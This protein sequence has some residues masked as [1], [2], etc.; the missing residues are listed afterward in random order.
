MR[1]YRTEFPDFDPATMPAIPSTWSDDSWSKESCPAF[2]CGELR[3]FI[4][5][6]DPQD[7]EIADT[8]RF[9]VHLWAGDYP[10]AF[11]GD[12]WSDVLAFVATR[13]GIPAWERPV[14]TDGRVEPGSGLPLWSGKG[15][16]PAIGS[17]VALAGP[18][19]MTVRVEEYK[20]DGRWL[21]ILGERSDGKRGDLAG[22]EIRWPSEGAAA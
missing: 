22:A 17:I 13:H 20:V 9:S 3:I 16:P 5:Y 7:R 12:D 4:D 8:L 21:M 15:D 1:T 6:A 19:N 14:W 2:T 18:G 11:Q 10:M